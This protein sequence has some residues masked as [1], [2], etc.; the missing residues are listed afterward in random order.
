MQTG[1]VGL[2]ISDYICRAHSV[3]RTQ[4]QDHKVQGKVLALEKF[5]DGNPKKSDGQHLTFI[6]PP[7][8]VSV[9]S[10]TGRAPSSWHAT[11]LAPQCIFHY[12]QIQQ[13]HLSII[14]TYTFHFIGKSK[15]FSELIQL[16]IQQM[17]IEYPEGTWFIQD[18]TYYYVFTI[19]I[20]VMF[21][22]LARI[23]CSTVRDFPLLTCWNI[24]SKGIGG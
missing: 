22:L 1:H 2:C 10:A 6:P 24:S 14:K 16:F 17:F 12:F 5:A 18:Q 19:M 3:C 20:L 7:P 4:C 23:I 11:V 13:I 9:G 21:R 8:A 15:A